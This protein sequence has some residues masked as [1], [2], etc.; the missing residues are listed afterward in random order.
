MHLGC[1][2]SLGVCFWAGSHVGPVLLY[3][4]FRYVFVDEFD[5]FIDVFLCFWV[6]VVE[7][8]LGLYVFGVSGLRV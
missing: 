4:P 3:S 1:R 5:G 6:E 7:V 2:G 8:L